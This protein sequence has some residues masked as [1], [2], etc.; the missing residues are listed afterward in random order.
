MRILAS[1]DFLADERYQC[2]ID[3]RAVDC[4]ERY[5]R[6]FQYKVRNLQPEISIQSIAPDVF[7]SNEQRGQGSHSDSRVGI[8]R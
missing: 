4:I 1:I 2:A 7:M 6:I 3:S 8:G 5:G